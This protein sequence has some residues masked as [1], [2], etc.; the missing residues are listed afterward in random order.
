MTKSAPV[1]FDWNRNVTALLVIG[2]THWFGH[3]PT[4]NATRV[5]SAEK[6]LLR[7]IPPMAPFWPSFVGNFVEPELAE[8]SLPFRMLRMGNDSAQQS[9]P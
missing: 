6:P 2:S 4:H 9:R 5:I 7:L 1:A 3:S 8:L